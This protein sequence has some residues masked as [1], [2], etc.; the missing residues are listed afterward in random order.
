VLKIFTSRAGG[1]GIFKYPFAKKPL[2]FV[3]VWQY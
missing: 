2:L 3:F 1:V